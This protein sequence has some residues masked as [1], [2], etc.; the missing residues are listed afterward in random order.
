[1]G[2]LAKVLWFL[3]VFFTL[4]AGPLQF[5]PCFRESNGN[6]HHFLGWIYRGTVLPGW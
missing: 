1:V 5:V 3:V 2:R 6:R 4:L